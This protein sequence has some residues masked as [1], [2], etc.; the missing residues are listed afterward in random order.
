MIFF[1][2]FRYV[3][4]TTDEILGHLE[5]MDSHMKADVVLF[6]PED[7]DIT[8]EDSEDEEELQ[9]KDVNH[10]GRGVLSQAAELITH[11]LQEEEQEEAAGNKRG[12]PN[13]DD[14]DAGGD[15][16][17]GY[18]GDVGDDLREVEPEPEKLA[19]TKNKDRRWKTTKPNIHGM[20]VPEFQEQPLK[21]LP[22]DT[23]T[24]YEFYL[25]FVD[26]SFIDEVV[27]KSRLYADRKG[28]PE[29]HQLI[30]ADNIRIAHAIMFMTGYI[31]PANRR[32]Y[33]ETR[34][35]TGNSLVKNAMSLRTFC[36]INSNTVFV[37]APVPDP[38]DKFWKVRALFDQLN[39]TAKLWVRQGGK[40]SID[41][42]MV[43][44]FGPHPTKKF[45]QLKPCR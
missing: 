26:D 11:V 39:Q 44:Y 22:P 23:N 13:D 12:R 15:G 16:D 2:Y 24:P 27:R 31:T 5:E 37:E 18:V 7:N 17:V 45:I 38:N 34:E 9:E 32:M 8:D 19:R 6:P 10:L 30:T 20:A 35:D 14:D 40:V 36:F 3:G 4:L 42:A 33:W 29:A 41:E 25:L 43:K 1:I 21:T 28:R